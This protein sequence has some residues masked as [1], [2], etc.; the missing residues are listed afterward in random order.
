[1]LSSL[2]RSTDKSKGPPNKRDSAVSAL[3]KFLTYLG[4]KCHVR[5]LHFKNLWST[6]HHTVH[7][8]ISNYKHVYICYF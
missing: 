7:I 3:H 4:I 2:D 6:S 5:A 1:M 8:A